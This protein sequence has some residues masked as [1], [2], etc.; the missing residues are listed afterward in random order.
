MCKERVVYYL[1]YIYILWG[2][3]DKTRHE[4]STRNDIQD[5][6]TEPC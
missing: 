5:F 3:Q 2:K 6:I 1:L 4:C